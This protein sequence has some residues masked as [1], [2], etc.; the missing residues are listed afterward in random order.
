MSKV[1]TVP[2]RRACTAGP[3]T[4]VSVSFP[5]E[6]LER[7]RKLAHT[8]RSNVSRVVRE[9]VEAHLEALERP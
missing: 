3:R 9:A 8:T 1:G 7:V 2:A 4:E 6:L 5:D